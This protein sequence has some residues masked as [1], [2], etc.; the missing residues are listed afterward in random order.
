[1]SIEFLK[2]SVALP[3]TRMLQ[4]GGQV[5]DC[6]SEH[7]RLTSIVLADDQAYLLKWTYFLQGRA[8]API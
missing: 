6:K 8:E 3:R 1:M 4:E 2:A 5:P 7:I